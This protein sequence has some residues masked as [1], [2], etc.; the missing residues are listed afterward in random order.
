MRHGDDSVVNVIP[1][2]VRLASSTYVMRMAN[3]SIH[4]PRFCP[5]CGQNSIEAYVR[6]GALHLYRC[7]NGH[8]FMFDWFADFSNAEQE[9]QEQR[10]AERRSA[11]RTL[12]S[13]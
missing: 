8:F 11:P 9:R 10:S 6:P 13:A 12:A 3:E 1:I 2:T 7:G 4:T 5:I